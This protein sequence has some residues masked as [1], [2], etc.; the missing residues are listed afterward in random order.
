MRACVGAAR[1]GLGGAADGLHARP[2]S[3]QLDDLP[4]AAPSAPRRS[5][6]CQPAQW[7]RAA[8]L[9][10]DRHPGARPLPPSLDRGWGQALQRQWH[11]PLQ[12]RPR[13]PGRV[14]R[15]RGPG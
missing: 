15:S 13:V 6:G 9:A 11:R 5:G 4:P 3:A 10:G 1:V 2:A 12:L 8:H 7:L 14:L